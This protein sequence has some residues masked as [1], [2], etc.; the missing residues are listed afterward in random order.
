MDLLFRRFRRGDGTYLEETNNFL[1]DRKLK[2]LAE[3]IKDFGGGP[4][5]MDQEQQK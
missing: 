1:V 2:E 3:G 4:G 5:N